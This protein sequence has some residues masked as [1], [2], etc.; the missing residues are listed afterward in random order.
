MWMNVALVVLK[1]LATASVSDI[2]REIDVRFVTWLMSTR[3]NRSSGDTCPPRKDMKMSS[4][5]RG[6]AFKVPY[7]VL[8]KQCFRVGGNAGPGCV[9]PS[10][11]PV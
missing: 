7:Y 8:E 5:L 2:H 3:Q 1:L 4:Q 10:W 9:R 11:S 6:L